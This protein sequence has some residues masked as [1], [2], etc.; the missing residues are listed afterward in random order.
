[1]QREIQGIVVKG[2]SEDYNWDF[3]QS[4]LVEGRIISDSNQNEIITVPIR[5]KLHRCKAKTSFSNQKPD[6]ITVRT[7][8]LC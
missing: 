6:Q 1:M 4:K 3:I 5:I 8:L 2:V 7:T